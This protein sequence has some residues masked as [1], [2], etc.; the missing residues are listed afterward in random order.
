[1]NVEALQEEEKLIRIKISFKTTSTLVVLCYKFCWK[2][3][4]Y[5]CEITELR[6]TLVLN[7]I[8][9]IFRLQMKRNVVLQIQRFFLSEICILLILQT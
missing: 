4:F 8:Q 1:M 7:P 2:I 6:E 3:I 9:R 5:S